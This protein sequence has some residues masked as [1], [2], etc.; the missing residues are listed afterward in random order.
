MRRL[1]RRSQVKGQ[2]AFTLI[3]LLVVMAIIAIIAAMLMPALQR[4]REAAQRTSCLNN[5]RDI[6]NSLAMYTS[7]HNGQMPE[8]CNQANIDA[9][10][11]VSTWSKNWGDSWDE[12]YPSYVSDA[13]LFWCPSDRS[14]RA[15]RYG[16][17]MGVNMKVDLIFEEDDGFHYRN[18]Q[19]SD[20]QC[21]VTQT[22]RQWWLDNVGS[23][24]RPDQERACRRAGI[25]SADDQSYAF[26][27]Q[28]CVSSAEEQRS[29]DMRVAGDNEQEGDEVQNYHTNECVA[30]WPREWQRRA[31]LPNYAGYVAP[32]YRYV[33]G[34]E[35][36]DNHGDD[37]VN[38]LYLDWHAKFDSRDWPS[39]LGTLFYRFENEPRCQ[40]G[41]P[42]R[43]CPGA[44]AG[45]YNENLI[46]RDPAGNDITNQFWRFPTDRAKQ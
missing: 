13:K 17:N 10:G 34:L 43:N 2:G 1:H 6:S 23:L 28:E 16:Y 22:E 27:G 21:P 25:C 45:Q 18:D 26:V 5:I 44:V 42:I 9:A 31:S 12:L 29:A 19:Y 38:V 20:F 33:G 3:E 39:P 46:C 32:G 14:D 24:T 37:G 11:N 4:A 7:E 15:P 8:R 36:A 41:Q 40:W 30:L 35:V